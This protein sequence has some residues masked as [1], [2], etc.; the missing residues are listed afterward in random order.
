MEF[1]DE[2]RPGTM[3]NAL[4]EGRTEVDSCVPVNYKR[5]RTAVVDS[6]CPG[7]HDLQGYVTKVM[8]TKSAPS[9][10]KRAQSRD[11][12]DT[13][14]SNQPDRGISLPIMGVESL[15]SRRSHVS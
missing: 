1:G 2:L 3:A 4:L 5:Y 8:V 9:I 13:C 11:V 10:R 15:R 6:T 7:S 12:M 14:S